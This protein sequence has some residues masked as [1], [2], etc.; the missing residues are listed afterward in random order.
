MSLPNSK[1]SPE[2]AISGGVDIVIPIYNARELTNVCVK[3]VLKHATGDWRLILIDDASNVPGLREDLQEFAQADSRVHFLSNEK[4][5]GFIR[6]ANRGM[7]G[8][9]GRDVLL[10]NSDTEVYSGFLDRLRACAH[11]DSATGVLSPL[12][13]NATI[14]SIPEFG[15][16]NPI[17]E[18]FTR[19]SFAALVAAC[20]QRRRPEIVTAVGFC[21]YIKGLVI[22][23]IGYFDES[24]GRGF[25]EEN[26]FCEQ[27]KKAGFTIRLCDD[28][29]VYHEGKAS[30]GQEGWALESRNALLLESKQPGYHAAIA[31]F[32]E[33]NPLAP[34]QE[35]IRF[36]TARLGAGRWQA[37]LF[38]LPASPFK[39]GASATELR[40]RELVRALMLPRVVIA[41]PEGRRIRLAEVMGGDIA[42]PI[43]FS[44]D[45]N[46]V[47]ETVKIENEQA[48]EHIRNA[49]K[50][51]G[52]AGCIFTSDAMRELLTPRLSIPLDRAE[53]IE[54]SASGHAEWR[55]GL[56]RKLET[57][58]DIAVCRKFYDRLKI[59]LPLEQMPTPEMLHEVFERRDL[60]TEI[61]SKQ[62]ASRSTIAAPKYQSSWWY[63]AFQ[64]IK[65]LIPRTVRAL[66]RSALVRLERSR[67]K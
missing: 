9:G 26:D 29:F 57:L 2:G 58:D 34:I 7:Q 60:S 44:F 17:P 24:F 11:A 49:I 38:L 28:V 30:F 54:P 40:V 4:N 52:V 43:F 32:F 63:P 41:Y 36:H 47:S 62:G 59:G 10:L 16:P 56:P 18:G 23:Q 19:D 65:P 37:L 61:R 35:E 42:R 1:T 20:S 51:F 64:K 8:A 67:S 14:C 3:S 66:G 27:A 6:T 46:D 48:L 15:E 25:G 55:R 12:S 22:E 31:K 50:L 39:A 53:S 33:E 13:N 5:E 21:M 45:V